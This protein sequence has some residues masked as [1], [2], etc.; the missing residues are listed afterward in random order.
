LHG[1]IS[2]KYFSYIITAQDAK[3]KP[4]PEGLF[5]GMKFLDVQMADCIIAGDSVNDIR[6][7]KA[8]GVKTVVYCQD[9]FFKKS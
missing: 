5:V 2:Q 7:G 8:A 1:L 9:C 3:P 4:S 6:A